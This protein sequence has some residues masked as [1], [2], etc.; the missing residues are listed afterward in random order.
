MRSV[1]SKFPDSCDER[2]MPVHPAISE[3]SAFCYKKLFR[4]KKTMLTEYESFVKI[5]LSQLERVFPKQD[6]TAGFNRLRPYG[7]PGRMPKTAGTQLATSVALLI[8]LEAQFYKLVTINQCRTAYACEMVNK[9]SKS[10]LCYID[11]DP[12]VI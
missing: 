3:K 1:F 8:E 7:Q 5:T 4:Q 12:I 9:S 11:S 6:T 2:H 10:N